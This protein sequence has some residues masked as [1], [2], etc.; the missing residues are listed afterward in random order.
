MPSAFE[1]LIAANLPTLYAQFGLVATFTSSNGS[2]HTLGLDGQPIIVRV[3]REDPLAVYR[4]NRTSG[5]IQRATIMVQASQLSNPAR[6]GR[7]MVEGVEVWTIENTA[8]HQNGEHIL[9]CSRSGTE[10]TME[11]SARNG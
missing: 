4:D 10:R 3:H 6:G 1:T 11:R 9:T 2:V 8:L 7:F 5:E